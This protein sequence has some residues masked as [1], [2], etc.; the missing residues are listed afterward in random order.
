MTITTRRDD[1][2]DAAFRHLKLILANVKKFVDFV[3][4]PEWLLVL[5][6]PSRMP[7]SRGPVREAARAVLSAWDAHSADPELADV[8][9]HMSMLRNAFEDFVHAWDAQQDARRIKKHKYRAAREAR[10]KCER[11][12]SRVKKYLGLHFAANDPR[13]ELYGFHPWGKKG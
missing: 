2:E 4:G 5:D 11:F 12:V 1:E 13:W 6:I 9:G 10:V 3:A 7:R 8:A